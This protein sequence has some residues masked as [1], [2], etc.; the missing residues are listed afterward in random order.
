M[1]VTELIT[2]PSVKHFL[3]SNAVKAYSFNDGDAHGDDDHDGHDDDDHGGHGDGDRD[4]HDDDH[5]DHDHDGHGVHD[6][7]A[8]TLL[9]LFQSSTG[10]RQSKRQ[11]I[12]L[13]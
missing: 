6:D 3:D 7:D 5:D 10:E 12:R 1:T 2:P 8:L 11:Q 9:H 4:G 13:Q